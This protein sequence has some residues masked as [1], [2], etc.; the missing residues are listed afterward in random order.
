MSMADERS[1]ANL[2]IGRNT[3]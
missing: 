3:I 2:T 1:G